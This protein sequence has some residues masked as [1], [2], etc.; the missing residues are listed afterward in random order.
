MKRTETGKFQPKKSRKLVLASWSHYCFSNSF[1]RGLTAKRVNYSLYHLTPPQLEGGP[2]FERTLRSCDNDERIKAISYAEQ[3]ELEGAAAVIPRF[4]N[5]CIVSCFVTKHISS[6]LTVF[7]R[8]CASKTFVSLS[9]AYATSRYQPRKSFSQHSRCL[10][11]IL[12][13]TSFPFR[14]P[15]RN[16]SPTLLTPALRL[17]SSL[18]C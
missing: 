9:C 8:R 13:Y 4:D 10:S 5:A 11:V 6:N 16:T 7:T 3:E 12:G 1:T 14:R 17:F 2:L 15:F 18:A